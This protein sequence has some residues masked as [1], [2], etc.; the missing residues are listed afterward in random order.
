M[1]SAADMTSMQGTAGLT[2]VTSCTIQ[3][4]TLVSDGRGG[5][6]ASWTTIAT[7]TCCI[8]P[9]MRNAQRVVADRLVLDNRFALLLAPGTDIQ[10]GDRVQAGG[11]QFEVNEV[12]AP[13]T[14]E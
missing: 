4:N 6:T 9:P 13:R 2:R 1:L 11:S 5:Q 3:R 14:L 7:T 8:W 10:P 12:V